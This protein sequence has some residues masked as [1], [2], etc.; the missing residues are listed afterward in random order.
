MLFDWLATGQVLA[1]NPA[2]A[3]KG[4]SHVVT[5]GRLPCSREIR[6]GDLST[7]GG[8]L[9]SRRPSRP[10]A[11]RRHGIHLRL[12]LRRRFDSIRLPGRKALADAL[13]ADEGICTRRQR[14]RE[15]KNPDVFLLK[16]A[17]PGIKG[18]IILR[19]EGVCS[20]CGR[21]GQPAAEGTPIG[22]W[23]AAPCTA[24]GRT[25]PLWGATVCNGRGLR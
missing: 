2:H 8:F 9:R 15:Q 19:Q 23:E 3:A 12:G 25:R 1:M 20:I 6:R 4:P 18:P 21:Q 17:C 11:H 5:R 16:A 24:L 14:T 22:D 13:P 10:G 7:Q